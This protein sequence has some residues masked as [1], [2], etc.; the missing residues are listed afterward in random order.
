ME[1]DWYRTQQSF[2][3]GEW[4]RRKRAYRVCG[5]AS[6]RSIAPPSYRLGQDHLFE[7]RNY[8][9][10]ESD[11]TSNS[12]HQREENSVSYHQTGGI[13][14]KVHMNQKISKPSEISHSSA[15]VIEKLMGLDQLHDRGIVPK[16]QMPKHCCFQQPSLA[17]SPE[18]FRNAFQ[19]MGSS[20]M[21]K[22]K[23]KPIIKTYPNLQKGE[24]GLNFTRKKFV[25]EMGF[26]IDDTLS[27]AEESANALEDQDFNKELFVKFN[28]EPKFLFTRY[29]HNVNSHHGRSITKFKSLDGTKYEGSKMCCGFERKTKRSTGHRW[30][31]SL[32][33]D[34]FKAGSNFRSANLQYPVKTDPYTDP[35]QFFVSGPC[36]KKYHNMGSS[37]SS[38]NDAQNVQLNNRIQATRS[39]FLELHAKRRDQ[40]R[41][42][43]N[44]ADVVTKAKG[45][46]EI[47]R[48]VKQLMKQHMNADTRRLSV[49][50]LDNA[51]HKVGYGHFH[52]C[53]DM[54][55]LG[56]KDC[57]CGGSFSKRSTTNERKKLQSFDGEVCKLPPQDMHMNLEEWRKES[58]G[59]T[60]KPDLTGLSVDNTEY[61]DGMFSVSNCMDMDLLLKNKR[62]MAQ[63]VTA[64][65]ISTL[66]EEMSCNHL[67]ETSSDQP[68]SVCLPIFKGGTETQP[69]PLASN[70]QAVQLNLI[71][72]QEFPSMEDNSEICMQFQIAKSNSE[73]TCENY[74]AFL[75]LPN[76]S[77]FQSLK[78]NK[79]LGEFRDE[80]ERDFSYV[81]DMLIE[82]GIDDAKKGRLYD[83]SDLLE[84]DMC[85]DVFG[86][87]EKK[88]NKLALWSSSER[89][90]LFD[91]INSILVESLA[92]CLHPWVN[93]T[94]MVGP[95]WGLQGLAQKAWEI[96]VRKRK[97]L[98]TGNAEAKVLVPKWLDLEDDIDG[99]GKEI[100]EMLQEEL[101]DELV[102][103]F[104]L[105]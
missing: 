83:A 59:K 19:V 44:E 40:Q 89:K 75:K 88:Y 63:E 17:A 6:S 91:L 22:N 39:R 60:L 21:E 72:A 52:G 57:S 13:P 96:L 36:L 55:Y 77:N 8:S 70:K 15:S 80:E 24:L 64:D 78:K 5:G 45:S 71:Y 12:G 1:G 61:L 99:I 2:Q 3:S 90:L 9:N 58:C 66:N 92:P 104:I 53:K 31:S 18:R 86:K 62:N 79:D 4:P 42:S 69:Q 68:S 7:Q 49:V 102:S 26:S 10:V 43:S 93:S 65:V 67:K 97:E 95:V 35:S 46:M 27:T 28:Q 23:T 56:S 11:S 82:S 51:R 47:S 94:H 41:L 32:F 16:Q 105:G 87:L 34:S 30:N 98:F 33:H 14:I 100:G 101:L 73:V 37:I 20:K 54:M 38:P 76:V 74:S 81:L 48:D 84:Y 29:R 103:E 25:G 85:T 50:E